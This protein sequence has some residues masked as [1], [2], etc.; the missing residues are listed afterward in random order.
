MRNLKDRLEQ[1]SAE[2]LRMVQCSNYRDWP[3][4][5]VQRIDGD[6]TETW[7]TDQPQECSNCGWIAD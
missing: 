7:E 5:C 3:P 4:V 6:G 1:D 2:R